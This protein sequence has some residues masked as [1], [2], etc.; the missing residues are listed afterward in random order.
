M[1]ASGI[2]N[3]RTAFDSERDRHFTARAQEGYTT[4]VFAQRI[5]IYEAGDAGSDGEQYFPVEIMKGFIQKYPEIDGITIRLRDQDLV[6]DWSEATGE[7]NVTQD[8]IR[9]QS[10][11]DGDDSD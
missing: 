11:I 3:V 8:L 1:I 7:P 4:A 2:E 5:C 9:E 10:D 6:A